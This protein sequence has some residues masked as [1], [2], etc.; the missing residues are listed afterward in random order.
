[1]TKNHWLLIH[2]RIAEFAGFAVRNFMTLESDWFL[3]EKLMCNLVDNYARWL[4]DDNDYINASQSLRNKVVLNEMCRC[5]SEMCKEMK[6]GA[7]IPSHTL[8]LA[9]NSPVI[10]EWFSHS[11]LVNENDINCMD[12]KRDALFEEAYLVGKN[13]GG[14][15][16][17]CSHDVGNLLFD[18]GED[19]LHWLPFHKCSKNGFKIYIDPILRN[20]VIIMGS[21][22]ISNPSK[23]G[24][25]KVHFE[26]ENPTQNSLWDGCLKG[27]VNFDIDGLPLN[28][29]D[30]EF[31]LNNKV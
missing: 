26:F 31:V 2:S 25:F 24:V 19:D 13:F 17:I 23:C 9:N 11:V 18:F 12:I 5:I 10:G 20:Q 27:I 16:F 29:F 7:T 3:R 4:G 8:Y 1:M 22:H 30:R 28:E 6:L 14:E 21:G 15:W